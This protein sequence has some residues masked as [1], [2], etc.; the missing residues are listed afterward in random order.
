MHQKGRQGWGG[1]GLK[2]E[3]F[4]KKA[5]AHHCSKSEISDECAVGPAM[6]WESPFQ[7]NLHSFL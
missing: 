7:A 6:T 1:L 2:P 3:W 5:F 4:A